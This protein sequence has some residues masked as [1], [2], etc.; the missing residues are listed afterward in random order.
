[1][2]S[3]IIDAA[4]PEF[5]VIGEPGNPVVGESA[6]KMAQKTGWTGGPITNTCYTATVMIKS[7]NPPTQYSALCQV[8]ASYARDNGDS[9]GSVFKYLGT[10]DVLFM[11]IHMGGTGPPGG[12]YS[13]IFSPIHRI[14]MDFPNGL[15]TTG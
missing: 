7:W 10:N 8:V 2:G 3:V 4:N 14:R 5:T 11:G 13:G 1:M 6:D 15:V 12:P 9:G